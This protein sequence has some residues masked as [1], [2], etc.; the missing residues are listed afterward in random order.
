MVDI[1]F[2]T[3]ADSH[4]AHAAAVVLSGMDGDGSIGIKR[5]KERGGLTVAQ[6]PDE[7]MHGS[8][9]RSA[10]G[11][12]MVDWVLPVQEMPARLLSYFRLEG[13]VSLPVEE[14]A[15]ENRHAGD[16]ED[17]LRDVLSFL[18]SR[19]SR[20]FSQYKRATVLRRIARRMQVNGVDNLTG[21]LNV[22][23]T[24]PGECMALL[25]DLLISVTNF[26]R[27]ADCWSALQQHLPALFE[28]KGPNDTVRVWAIACATGE[29]AYSP[30][31]LLSEYARDLEAPPLIRCSRPIST[32]R[33][34]RPRAKGCTPRRSWPT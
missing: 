3:L 15:P 26:F 8:M 27:D 25:Q 12:G 1:F 23:R 30:A 10:I 7:A 31:M 33:P 11:T 22:L 34:C 2:R 32:S 16:D 5:I 24:R 20:D 9:P 4:G 18:R 17:R 13:T 19:T 6:D 21:Y 14:P 29:E 28:G